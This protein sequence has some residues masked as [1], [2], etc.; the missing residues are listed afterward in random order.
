MSSHVNSGVSGHACA[1]RAWASLAA[2]PTDSDLQ[3]FTLS[4]KG[5]SKLSIPLGAGSGAQQRWLL[6]ADTM[7]WCG[8]ACVH[9]ERERRTHQCER[10]SACAT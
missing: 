10:I 8:N 9:H 1:R 6:M 5:P 3:V 4:Q 7:R 2:Y